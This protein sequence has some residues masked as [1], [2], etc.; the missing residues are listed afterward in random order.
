MNAKQA[1][2]EVLDRLPDDCS[3]H[4]VLYHVYVLDAIERGEEDVRAGRV[5]PHE[6]VEAQLRKKW[7]LDDDA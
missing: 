3:I 4:D 5:I 6:E 1:V 2:R 7:H